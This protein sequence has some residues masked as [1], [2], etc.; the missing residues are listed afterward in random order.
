M[1]NTDSELAITECCFRVSNSLGL[2]FDRYGPVHTAGCGKHGFKAL[3]HA[4]ED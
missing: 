1:L 2:F 4:V 3:S